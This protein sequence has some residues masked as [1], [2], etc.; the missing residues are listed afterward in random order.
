MEDPLKKGREHLASLCL[1]YLRSSY[2]IFQG[3]IYGYFTD[4]IIIFITRS[5]FGLSDG[6]TIMHWHRETG[7]REK[8]TKS[9]GFQNK[10]ESILIYDSYK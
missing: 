3:F 6:N 4:I 10:Y 2:T 8:N 9:I 5:A 1:R 7:Y